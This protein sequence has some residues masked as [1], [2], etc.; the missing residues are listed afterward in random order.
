MRLYFREQVNTNWS[1]YSWDYAPLLIL[2]FVKL[3]LKYIW[4]TT[5]PSFT[6]LSRLWETIQT[7][8]PSVPQNS[9]QHEAPHSFCFSRHTPMAIMNQNSTYERLNFPGQPRPS[10]TTNT[11]SSA[12]TSC[13]LSEE[14][15]PL[16]HNVPQAQRKW[17]GQGEVHR[18]IAHYFWICC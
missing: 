15:V 1:M 11:A 12:V 16:I 7:N 14:S 10:S 18:E 4:P 2:S 9:G 13:W 3:L 6:F 5:V 17:K 8:N